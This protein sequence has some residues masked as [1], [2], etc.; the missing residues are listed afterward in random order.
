MNTPLPPDLVPL[1]RALESSVA[2]PSPALRARILAAARAAKAAPLARAS[3]RSR[4]P[5]AWF[6]ASAAAAVLLLF[7]LGRSATF[8]GPLDH[9]APSPA[10]CAQLRTGHA[11]RLSLFPTSLPRACEE[12]GAQSPE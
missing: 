4:P 7:N 5:R 9:A 11:S 1:E 2:E 10:L 3:I 6:A 8:D 12:H